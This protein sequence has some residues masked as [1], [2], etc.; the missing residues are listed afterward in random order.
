MYGNF[1]SGLGPKYKSYPVFFNANN[2]QYIIIYVYNYK[3]LIIKYYL[4]QF[5][6]FLRNNIQFYWLNCLLFLLAY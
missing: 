6:F 5:F 1:F 2:K 3:N 4:I